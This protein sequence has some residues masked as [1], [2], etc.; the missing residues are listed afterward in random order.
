LIAPRGMYHDPR[1]RRATLIAR[2]VRHISRNENLV[3]GAYCSAPFQTLAVVYGAFAIKKVGDRLDTPMAMCFRSCSARHRQDIH[4]DTLRTDRF[5][6]GARTIFEALLADIRSTRLDHPNTLCRR[7]RHRHPSLACPEV[8]LQGP[9]LSTRQSNTLLTC[10]CQRHDATLLPP[11]GDC[12]L[13]AL[14]PAAHRPRFG[15][16]K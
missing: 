9:Y 15:R 14:A 3:S 1:A 12:R 10:P 11:T 13:G 2:R 16:E 5:G 4:A 7:S 6:R 8:H